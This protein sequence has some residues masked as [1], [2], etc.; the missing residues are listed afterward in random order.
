MG[1]FEKRIRVVLEGVDNAT[2]YIQK[3]EK[4]LLWRVFAV[5]ARDRRLFSSF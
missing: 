1:D 3:L 5:L 4:S 2:S